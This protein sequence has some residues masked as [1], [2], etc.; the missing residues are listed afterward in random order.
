MTY[1]HR[2]TSACPH[3]ITNQSEALHQHYWIFTL[4]SDWLE[5]LHTTSDSLD[6]KPGHPTCSYIIYIILE[7]TYFPV[8]GEASIRLRLFQC[9]RNWSIHHSQH[10]HTSLSRGP[11]SISWSYYAQATFN[12]GPH[13]YPR[14]LEFV[15]ELNLR[16]ISWITKEMR[17]RTRN[18]NE[19]CEGEINEDRQEPC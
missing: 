8:I 6:T 3:T 14:G 16:Y 4:H 9:K 18:A 15:Q 11:V 13:T 12:K 5:T 1:F 7:L 2:H 19:S 17:L 10:L